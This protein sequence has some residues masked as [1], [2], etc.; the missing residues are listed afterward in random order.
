MD[1]EKGTTEHLIIPVGVG[2]NGNSPRSTNNYS[3]MIVGVGV[4]K[5]KRVE[6][7]HYPSVVHMGKVSHFVAIR[8]VLVNL[9]V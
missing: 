3:I 4:K 6:R 5:S 7:E 2:K 8:G 1:S 9:G